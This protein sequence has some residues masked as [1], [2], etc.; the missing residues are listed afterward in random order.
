MNG[1]SLLIDSLSGLS[2]VTSQHAV[3]RAGVKVVA[4][5]DRRGHV[6][7]RALLAQGDV[8]VRL[9]TLGER[10]VA[11]RRRF[12]RVDRL[13]RRIARRDEDQVVVFFFKQKTAYEVPK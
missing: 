13:D 3:V 10:D 9:L 7:A 8:V 4:V 2:V 1:D 11:G 5:N 6:S 12:D